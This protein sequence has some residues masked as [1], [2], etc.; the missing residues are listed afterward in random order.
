[1]LRDFLGEFPARWWLER[2]THPRASRRMRRQILDPTF[3]NDPDV[4]P[5]TPAVAILSTGSND[6]PPYGR[7]GA[8]CSINLSASSYSLRMRSRS[9]Q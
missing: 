1:M 6:G 9:G 7:A 5:A 4:A 2:I 3:A 8:F